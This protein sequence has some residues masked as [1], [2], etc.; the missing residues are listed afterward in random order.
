MNL[1]V[2][3]PVRIEMEKWGSAPHWHIPG[4]YLGADRLGDWI[5]VPAGTRM[6]RP[7]RE[8]TTTADHVTL[9][10]APGPDL[11]RAFMAAFHVEP[12][13][14]WV[15][16]DMTTPPT[17]DGSTVRAVDLDLDV[18]RGRE[19]DVVVD[20]EDEFARHQVEL[21]YPPEVVALAER[22]RDRVLQRVLDEEAP[23]DGSHERWQHALGR[24]SART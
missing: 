3:E 2:G 4:Y 20:D 9:V 18:V 21:G 24:L 8:A 16:V 1:Q 5:G 15:Y 17:W 12:M 22:S 7:G 10:P 14:V 13:D 6:V 11:E 19:G 23:F